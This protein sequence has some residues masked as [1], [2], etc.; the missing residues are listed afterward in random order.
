MGCPGGGVSSGLSTVHALVKELALSTY[1]DVPF[2]AVL[3]ARVWAFL[4][5]CWIA[6][7]TTTNASGAV[8][9]TGPS[10]AVRG[11]ATKANLSERTLLFV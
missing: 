4:N 10:A 7:T 9:P 1:A 3:R 2:D 8:T 11:A 5:S 6:A